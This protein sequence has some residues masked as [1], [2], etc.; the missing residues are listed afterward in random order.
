MKSKICKEN[1]KGNK[2]VTRR[3][4]SKDRQQK[5]GKQYVQKKKLHR[6]LTI[7]QHEPHQKWDELKWSGRVSSACSTSV[8]LKS[9]LKSCNRSYMRK[10][11]DCYYDERNNQWSFL[12][13]IFHT[14]SPSH[15]GYRKTFKV[16]T[17]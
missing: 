13:Q 1:F 16:M 9:C 17:T 4:K 8:M 10:G 2:V 3:R 7:E 5:R 14:C 11:P 15:G 6:K 12:A